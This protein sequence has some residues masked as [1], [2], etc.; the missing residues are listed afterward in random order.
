MTCL[1][2][3]VMAPM[4]YL[5]RMNQN[6]LAQAMSHGVWP[7]IQYVEA[8]RTQ[9]SY[10]DVALFQFI[11]QGDIAAKSPADIVRPSSTPDGTLCLSRQYLLM[12]LQEMSDVTG[13]RDFSLVSRL[14]M[15]LN[16]HLDTQSLSS[17]GHSIIDG[18]L[19]GE[20]QGL[21]VELDNE[22]SKKRLI[23]LDLDANMPPARATLQGRSL[24]VLLYALVT[25]GRLMLLLLLLLLS[26]AMRLVCMQLPLAWQSIA[27]HACHA[28]LQAA[29]MHTHGQ[30][31]AT[32]PP[33]QSWRWQ[34][35]PLHR[36]VLLLGRWQPG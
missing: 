34:T 21:V 22:A 3:S 32:C 15:T 16:S 12:C 26:A 35:D 9:P 18:S 25:V 36:G 6:L 13:H 8:P 7:D 11:L 27:E 1:N 31:D 23:D 17:T 20:I 33:A 10:R 14:S 28:C 30:T 5:S 4:G 24:Q 19:D 29:V 2:T